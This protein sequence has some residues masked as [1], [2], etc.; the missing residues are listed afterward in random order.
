MSQSGSRLEVVEREGADR[1]HVEV[2][3]E[4]AASALGVGR[5]S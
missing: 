3:A 4:L 1:R 2:E 5:V